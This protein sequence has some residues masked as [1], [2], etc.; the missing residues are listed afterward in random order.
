MN[1]Q[2]I[3]QLLINRAL[4]EKRTK[5][6]GMER[7]H[8]LPRSLGGNNDV[9][10]LVY[11]SAREHFVAHK[12]LVKIHKNN[13]LA[14]KKMIYALWQMSIQRDGRYKG[15]VSSHTYQKAKEEYSKLHPNKDPERKQ[16]YREKRAA[17]L[18]KIDNKKAGRHLSASL[19]RKSPEELLARM[20]N[21]TLKCDQLKRAEAI[22]KGKGSLLQIVQPTGEIKEFWSFDN[23]MEITGLTYSQ[24]RYRIKAHNG[25]LTDGSKVSYVHM[26]DTNHQKKLRSILRYEKPNGQIIEFSPADPV[27][28]LTGYSYNQIR[29]RLSVY[30]GVMP[31]GSKV[32]WL[33]KYSHRNDD[34][35]N[36]NSC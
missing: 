5:L 22:K 14:H 33:Q 20:K 1:Y 32:Y 17:G 30:N 28:T 10:N 29:R 34:G 26:Y 9:S 24:L 18:Y 27:E 25:L 35:R 23:I 16:R 4:L 3:Y 36:N 13:S 2:N 6:P 8:I 12:L 15:I 21:S 11:L 19:K 31:D 7:H